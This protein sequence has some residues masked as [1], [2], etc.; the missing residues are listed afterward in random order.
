MRTTSILRF[1]STTSLVALLLPLLILISIKPPTPR[2]FTVSLDN[3]A[4]SVPD[5]KNPFISNA[6][7]G[8]SYEWC[9]TLSAYREQAR[10]DAQQAM[11]KQL[12][13]SGVLI[14]VFTVLFGYLHRRNYKSDMQHFKDKYE[15]DN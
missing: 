10:K 5:L 1:I 6:G 11:R 4:P 8:L 14:G 15:F 9:G 12:T 13:I 2:A 7:F 3:Y